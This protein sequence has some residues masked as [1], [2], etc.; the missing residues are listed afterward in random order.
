MKEHMLRAFENRMLRRIF[1]TRKYDISVSWTKENNNK[2][3]NFYC[4][5]NIIR[6]IK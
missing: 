6:V 1:Q 4:A 5:P 2:L 3:H